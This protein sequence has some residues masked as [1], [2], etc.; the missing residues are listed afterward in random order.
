MSIKHTA[1]LLSEEDLRTKV[2]YEWL[3]E[4]GFTSS[5]IS[6]EYSFMMRLGK[7][8]YKVLPHAENVST[9]IARPRADILVKHKDG[10][11]LMIIELKATN[12]SLTIADSEQAL[13]YARLLR[14]GGIAPFTILTNGYDTHIYDSI[15]GNII[16][17]N[18]IPAEHSYIK[19]GFKVVNND[20]EFMTRA[21]ECFISLSEENLLQFCKLQV[22]SRMG[23]LKSNNLFSGKKYIPSL[24]IERKE[25]KQELEKFLFD[26][27]KS[28]SLI[29]VTGAP[30]HGKTNFICNMVGSLIAKG[31]PTLFYPAVDIDNGLLHAIQSDFEWII[32]DHSSI[33]TLIHS[34]LSTILNRTSSRLFIFIDGWNEANIELARTIDKECARLGNYNITIILS[35]TS[36]SAK[37]ILMNG[38]GDVSNFANSLA[39]TANDIATIEIDSTTLA[40]RIVT[41]PKYTANEAKSAMQKYAS[42]YSVKVPQ[43]YPQINEPFLLKIA[44]QFYRNQELP[45]SLDEVMLV[46]NYINEKIR[47]AKDVSEEQG[48]I[49]LGKLASCIFQNDSPVELDTAL[50]HLQHYSH[51]IPIS[52]YESA[53]LLKIPND[54]GMPNIEFYNDPEMHY[55][56]SYLAK[57]WHQTIISE[58]TLNTELELASKTYAGTISMRWYIKNNPNVIKNYA[59]NTIESMHPNILQMIISALRSSVIS[60]DDDDDDWM[61]DFVKKIVISEH[62]EVKAEAARFIIILIDGDD[63]E[64]AEIISGDT[65]F[66]I[67]ALLSDDNL[68]DMDSIDNTIFRAIKFMH[69]EEGGGYYTSITDTLIELIKKND[70]INKVKVLACLAN[71]SFQELFDLMFSDIEV[72]AIVRS[73]DY[74]LC[75]ATEDISDIY[76]GGMCRGYLS[77]LEDDEKAE[78]YNNLAPRFKQLIAWFPHHELSKL[79]QDILNYLSE[80]IPSETKEQFDEDL[81]VDHPNQLFFEFK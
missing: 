42:A 73:N 45:Y 46:R 5:D 35:L 19:N 36:L 63:D 32:G 53:L 56:I 68:V 15:T 17:G 43:N 79:L 81:I 28:R 23:K 44:M 20:L 10:R 1:S 41:V 74:I 67:E 54:M 34:K 8:V 13:S 18:H 76:F 80:A 3:K 75:Y 69:Q 50:E 77:C 66:Y 12:V 40:D 4:L 57:K 2:V 16:S 64:I 49:I 25:P 11:N 47:R 60:S 70:F 72:L 37:R 65:A 38:V 9:S 52:F 30:Q 26:Q 61:I 59:L 62:K 78:E 48:L 7:N 55:C 14:E 33:Y 71:C 29:L 27:D 22:E 21:L 24:Y 51:E 6:L 58:D 31:N 39:L